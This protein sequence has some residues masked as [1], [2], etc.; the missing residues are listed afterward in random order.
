M[1]KIV[2]SLIFFWILSFVLLV[3]SI[4]FGDYL[5]AISCQFKNEFA[6]WKLILPVG[7]E[8]VLYL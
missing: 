2:S 3:F 6:F 1:T 4:L 5:H 8:S 7:D